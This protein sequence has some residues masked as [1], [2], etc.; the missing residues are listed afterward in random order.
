MSNHQHSW[1]TSG[2][3][4]KPVVAMDDW[5]G[6]VMGLLRCAECGLYGLIYLVAWEAPELRNRIFALRMVPRQA[7]T[8]YLRN[9]SS[10]YCDLTRKQSE[11]DALLSSADN[12]SQLLATTDMTVQQ[13]VFTDARPPIVAW[14]DIN[15]AD[16][17]Q[18]KKGFPG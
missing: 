11:T 4:I 12:V 7:A 16:Y 2:T 13:A 17:P 18:W 9:I 5:M 1:A 3:T 6:P 15:P 14:R 10:D 8:I